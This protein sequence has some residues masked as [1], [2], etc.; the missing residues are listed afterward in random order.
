MSRP[1]KEYCCV[2]VELLRK[3]DVQFGKNEMHDAFTAWLSSDQVRDGIAE[4]LADMRG[5]RHGLPK[6]K[7]VLSILPK[8]LKDE[9]FDDADAV[10]KFLGGEK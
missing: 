10:V 5:F 3:P 1:E 2:V 8:K 7:D 9:V 6:I 4:T